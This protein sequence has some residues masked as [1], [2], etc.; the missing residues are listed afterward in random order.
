MQCLGSDSHHTFSTHAPLTC[1]YFAHA[2]TFRQTGPD[3]C[4][5]LADWYRLGNCQITCRSRGQSDSWNLQDEKSSKMTVQLHFKTSIHFYTNRWSGFL[6][7]WSCT[8]PRSNACAFANPVTPISDRWTQSAVIASTSP[9]GLHWCQVWLIVHNLMHLHPLDVS[10]T[11][12]PSRAGSGLTIRLEQGRSISAGSLTPIWR[13]WSQ[14]TCACPRWFC[15]AAVAQGSPW[16]CHTCIYQLRMH[17]FRV[18]PLPIKYHSWNSTTLISGSSNTNDLWSSQAGSTWTKFYSTMSKTKSHHCKSVKSQQAS[19]SSL[20]IIIKV[21]IFEVTRYTPRETSVLW[22]S[23]Y[24]A[25]NVVVDQESNQYAHTVCCDI[26][27]Q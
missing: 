2:V 24:S 21:T 3:K 13:W 6:S 14:G 15:R 8:V 18:S 12:C 22:S 9:Y 4:L 16:S 10:V 17:Y 20:S 19:R 11:C 1:F 23:W 26:E 5:C 7:C 25:W 27:P